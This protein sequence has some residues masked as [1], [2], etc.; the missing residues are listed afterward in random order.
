MVIIYIAKPLFCHSPQCYH[1]L[2]ISILTRDG[3]MENVGTKEVVAN[4]NV[5]N[6]N[7]ANG[8]VAK[9]PTVSL[10]TT[11]RYFRVNSAG[12]CVGGSIIFFM[13]YFRLFF[14]YQPLVAWKTFLGF[15]ICLINCEFLY[16]AFKDLFTKTL[17]ANKYVKRRPINNV[18]G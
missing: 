2:F 4:G 6:G 13:Q 10:P 9:R 1:C 12:R 5:A 16:G 3:R 18:T 14:T 17:Y 7:V 11:D 8:N 15:F